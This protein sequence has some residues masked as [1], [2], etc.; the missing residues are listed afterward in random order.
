MK[1]DEQ[2]YTSVDIYMLT[3]G[4]RYG[5]KVFRELIAQQKKIVTTITEIQDEENAGNKGKF[6][7]TFKTINHKFNTS[8]YETITEV[9][10]DIRRFL[11]EVYSYLG[12]DHYLFRNVLTLEKVMEQKFAL[13]PRTYRDQCSIESTNIVL[14]KGFIN[15]QLYSNRRRGNKT[16]GHETPILFQ[17]KHEKEILEREQ[18][19][20]KEEEKR[21]KIEHLKK[22]YANFEDEMLTG[23]V[24]KELRT[25]W[26][27]PCVGILIYMLQDF[28]DI[29][30]FNYTEFELGSLYME[31]SGLFARILEAIFSTPHQR[32]RYKEKTLN[33]KKPPKFEV[34]FEKMNARIT[35]WYSTADYQGAEYATEKFGFCRTFFNSIG[36]DNPLTDVESFAQLRLQQKMTIMKALC[37]STLHTDETMCQCL[38][39]IPILQRQDLYLGQDNEK[40]SYYFFPQFNTT[41]VRL[42]KK[43]HQTKSNKNKVEHEYELV[44]WDLVSLDE[45]IKRFQ[46]IRKTKKSNLYDLQQTME[47]LHEELKGR[48]N[49]FKRHNEKAK[50][51]FMKDYLAGEEKTVD[52]DK[53]GNDSED[54][55]KNGQ[56]EEADIVDGK[57]GLEVNEDD[58]KPVEQEKINGENI[59]IVDNG[60][61]GNSEMEV[62]VDKDNGVNDELMN[63]LQRS[64]SKDE[65]SGES[66]DSK[67]EE[68]GESADSA[69]S[70][71]EMEE[72]EEEE[73]IESESEEELVLS[74]NENLSDADLT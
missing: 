43:Y 58:E 3:D 45:I 42:F 18:R 33:I 14:G 11:E 5:Y 35:K 54:S 6:S 26:E 1:N 52:E 50:L 66:A 16:E 73:I 4:L 56:N 69:S 9:A 30:D 74:E 71:E 28:F 44:A 61:S 22:E 34:L 39:N 21:K 53:D 68:S 40:H 31:K 36:E 72:S 37:E 24:L 38:T 46:K 49:E 12:T 10:A 59:S 48:E 8:T 29:R 70:E 63:G 32:K 65:E 64:E 19:Q 13:L 20:R 51:S 41:D 7:K 25:C 55:E 57:N 67:D 2:F 15:Q 27:V 62:D 23:Q 47:A 60:D 17:M